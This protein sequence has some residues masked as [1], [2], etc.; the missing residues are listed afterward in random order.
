MIFSPAF[1]EHGTCLLVWIALQWR[2]K[3]VQFIELPFVE[4]LRDDG[5]TCK[6]IR[7]LIP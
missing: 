5:K 1:S 2:Y 6:G 3:R 7:K 4:W